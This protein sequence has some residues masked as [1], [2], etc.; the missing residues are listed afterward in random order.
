MVLLGHHLVFHSRAG[1][2]TVLLDVLS[3]CSCILGHCSSPL[4]TAFLQLPPPLHHCARPYSVLLSCSHTRAGYI[5]LLLVPSL[6][7]V[8]VPD[9]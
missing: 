5:V 7:S 9:L 3:P 4:H 6:H 8:W 2:T 1:C